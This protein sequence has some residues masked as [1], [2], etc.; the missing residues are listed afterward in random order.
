MLSYLWFVLSRLKKSPVPRLKSF[1]YFE[2][3]KPFKTG[4]RI[5]SG[6]DFFGALLEDL[7]VLDTSNIHFKTACK[8]CKQPAKYTVLHR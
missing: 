3:S 7:G 6:P 5:R 2:M 4:P 8:M 1:P